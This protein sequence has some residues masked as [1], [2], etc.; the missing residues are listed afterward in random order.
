MK[1]LKIEKEKFEGYTHRFKIEFI[2]DKEYSSNI[3]L[4]SN[5]GDNNKVKDFIEKYKTK[6]VLSFKIINISTKQQ[7]DSNSILIDE[8]IKNI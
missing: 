1:K 3:D 4:Y 6:K 8:W 7:D 2:T 5:T